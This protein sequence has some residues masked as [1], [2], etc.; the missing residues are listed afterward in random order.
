MWQLLST[1]RICSTSLWPCL[2]PW[3]Y[4][5]GVLWHI[6]LGGPCLCRLA[7]S[8]G[9]E[10]HRR[11][12]IF[13]VQLLHKGPCPLARVPGCTLCG[14]FLQTGS[15][16][17]LALGFPPSKFVPWQGFGSLLASFLE[18]NDQTFFWSSTSVWRS[19]FFS[20]AGSMYR[21]GYATYVPWDKE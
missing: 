6:A 5:Q 7:P 20:P 8:V 11:L 2:W 17:L 13:W 21:N 16:W 14:S 4:L 19:G 9:L 18:V 3:R 10:H 15:R 12:N 1:P